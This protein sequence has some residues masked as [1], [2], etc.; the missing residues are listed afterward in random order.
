MLD[1]IRN[2]VYKEHNRIPIIPQFNRAMI[3]PA[4]DF[5][6]LLDNRLF[7]PEVQEN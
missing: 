7:S 5:M 2:K 3:S 4:T 1:N 6:T